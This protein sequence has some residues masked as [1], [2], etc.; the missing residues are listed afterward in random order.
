MPEM[1]GPEMWAELRDERPEAKALFLSG[2]GHEAL[3][4]NALDPR[5]AFLQKPFTL[6]EFDQKLRL[7]LEPPNPA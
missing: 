5:V 6:R 1:T 2:Y 3:Q 4:P 7:L